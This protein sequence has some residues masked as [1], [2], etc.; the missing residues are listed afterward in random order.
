MKRRI[1]GVLLI[2]FSIVSIACSEG[3][4]KDGDA[5]PV[6]DTDDDVTDPVQAECD[7]LANAQW[8]SNPSVI[9]LNDNVVVEG[10]AGTNFGYSVCEGA[11]IYCVG[12]YS[13]R[14]GL[15][16]VSCWE[17][18]PVADAPPSVTFMG[19]VPDG[20][21]GIKCRIATLPG[22]PNGPNRPEGTPY[23]F[24][25]AQYA[26]NPA[27]DT[28]AGRLYVLELDPDLGAEQNVESAA[29]YIFT[30]VGNEAYVDV[31]Y[32]PQQVIGRFSDEFCLGNTNSDEAV[33]GLYCLSSADF[34]A[35]PPGTEMPITD[36]LSGFAGR[37]YGHGEIE[38]LISGESMWYPFYSIP[39]SV[40]RAVGDPRFDVTGPNGGLVHVT[41]FDGFSMLALYGEP[42]QQ[43]GHTMIEVPYNGATAIIGSAIANDNLLI[44]D[45]GFID[46]ADAVVGGVFGPRYRQARESGGVG[47][48]PSSWGEVM[49]TFNVCGT[50]YVAISAPSGSETLDSETVGG[51]YIYKADDLMAAAE[52]QSADPENIDTSPLPVVAVFG[53][54]GGNFGWSL[55]VVPARLPL[56]TT[57]L[58]GNPGASS[59][60]LFT[61]GSLIE[62]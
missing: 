59:A 5:P 13:D 38:E 15:G 6:D 3:S 48:A 20:Y 55:E 62:P 39:L 11:G 50:N 49:R 61:L 25:S 32:V 60:H 56:D 14:N 34:W 18:T 58:V 44:G 37:F 7:Y 4:S 2:L 17:G 9:R 12:D 36:L 54:S 51:I 16:T 19:Q 40:G 22:D 42:G 57:F 47:F 30:G 24:A 41:A 46:P 33:G 53:P 21:L 28:N 1:W 8:Q 26:S 45:L 31:E 35:I 10:S 23:L 29:R 27:G 43:F 52:L